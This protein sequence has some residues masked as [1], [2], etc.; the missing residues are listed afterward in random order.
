M[1]NLL[2]LLAAALIAGCAATTPVRRVTPVVKPLRTADETTVEKRIAELRSLLEPLPVRGILCYPRA[3]MGSDIPLDLVFN[4]VRKL[5]FNH[6]RLHISSEVEFDDGLRAFLEAAHGF[7]IPVELMLSQRDFFVRERGNRLL[8]KIRSGT[9]GLVE[10]VHLAARF[11][12]SLPAEHR[13]AGITVVIE[14][15]YLVIGSPNLPPDAL[16]AWNEKT[17][18]PGLDN[19]LI[20]R[21]TFDVLRQLPEAAGDLP[22]S[23]AIPDFLHEKAL[24]GELT[25]GSIADFCAIDGI[26][27]V[28][29]INSGNRPSQLLAGISNEL[30]EAP[31][32]AKI[33][34]AVP[35]AEH[36]SVGAGALRRRDWKDFVRSLGYLVRNAGCHPAFEGVVVGPLAYLQFILTEKD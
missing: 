13:F 3:V 25:V 9:P 11:N 5:G 26:R 18:G 23:V 17:Y 35:V 32:G 28:I 34:I 16:F 21:R 2:L 29:V 36:S 12:A 30:K 6:L 8:R 22:V 20:M 7:G 1:K 33:V 24:S 31:K 10:A 15:Q 4:R 27:R 14:P 19:D